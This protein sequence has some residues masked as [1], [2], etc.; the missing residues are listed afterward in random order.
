M[1]EP[2]VGGNLGEIKSGDVYFQPP[3]AFRIFQYDQV[4]CWQGVHHRTDC[5]SRFDPVRFDVVRV[6]LQRRF[7]VVVAHEVLGRLE[8]D[9]G[10]DQQSAVRVP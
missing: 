2:P 3:T 1:P 8:V 9:S 7:W 10:G 6:D 5:G 4:R